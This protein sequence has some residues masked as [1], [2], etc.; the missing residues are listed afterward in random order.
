MIVSGPGE[1]WVAVWPVALRNP[2]EG[3]NPVNEMELVRVV[4]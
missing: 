2:A 3:V 4:V 1:L